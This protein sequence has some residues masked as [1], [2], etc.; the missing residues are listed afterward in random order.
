MTVIGKTVIKGDSYR[1]NRSISFNF[2]NFF[3][4]NTERNYVLECH[5]DN[6]LVRHQTKIRSKLLKNKNKNKDNELILKFNNI[7]IKIKKKKK[8]QIC[9]VKIIISPF[10]RIPYDFF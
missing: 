4:K 10:L 5:I 3:I 6:I 2:S 1:K 8:T 9:K 7:N